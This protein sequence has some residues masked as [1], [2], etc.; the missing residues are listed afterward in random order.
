MKRFFIFVIICIVVA[1]LA[2]TTYYLMSEQQSIK[3]L[4]TVYELNVGDMVDL[5]VEL[6]NVKS[7]NP[8]Q[9]ESLNP[10]VAEYSDTG[11][12]TAKAGGKAVL[13]VTSEIGGFTT[14]LIQITVG[15][16]ESDLTPLYIR[17]VDQFLHIGDTEYNSFYTLTASYRITTTNLNF[18]DKTWVPLGGESGFSGHIDFDGCIITNIT[19]KTSA[20]ANLGI[21]TKL[22]PNAVIS[23][24]I[25]EN[26]EFSG[27]CSGGVGAIAAINYGDISH[28]Y[29]NNT[30]I[31]NTHSSQSAGGIVGINYGIVERSSFENG[32]VTASK[33]AG[34]IVGENIISSSNAVVER[35]KSV[36][37]VVGTTAVGGIVGLNSGSHVIFCQ[38][39]SNSDFGSVRSSNA[40]SFIG[41]IVGENTYNGGNPSLVLDSYS[42][43]SVEGN[44]Y[45]GS[46][47]GTN[48]NI[49]EANND[50]N[51]VYG[52]YFCKDYTG[53]AAAVGTGNLAAGS[54]AKNVSSDDLATESKFF[55]Y[56]GTN[57]SQVYWDFDRVWDMKD[58]LPEVDFDGA[59]VS[60]A[61]DGIYI[62]GQ[63]VDVAGLIN[64][65]NSEA[66]LSK[67]YIIKANL[68][69]S[70]ITSWSPIGTKTSPFNGKLT[71]GVDGSGNRYKI[72]NLKISNDANS[73]LFGYVGAKGEI[74]N[75]VI[76]NTTISRGTTVGVVAAYNMGT[77]SNC[78]VK[79]S[80]SK[81]IGCTSA[82][83]DINIGGIAGF[84]GGTISGCKV[85]G[86]TI[87][88]GS[89][90]G[91][92]NYKLLYAGGITG[93]NDGTVENCINEATLD[94]KEGS[95]GNVGGLVGTNAG[96]VNLSYNSGV[97]RVSVNASSVVTGGIVGTNNGNAKLT[98]SFSD[99]TI[100]GCLA[101]GIV[102][103][104]NGTV[105]QCY[106]A[107]S[108]EGRNVGGLAY[109]VESG[110]IDNCYSSVQLSGVDSDSVKAGFAYI[111]AF[112]SKDNYGEISKC[113][114]S[115]S[116][117][118]SG[119]NW[120]ETPSLVRDPEIKIMG[121]VNPRQ[122]GYITNSMYDKDQS[123]NANTTV[124]KSLDWAILG[125]S[126]GGDPIPLSTDQCKTADK[127]LE[128]EF[129]VEYWEFKAGEYP[130]LRNV[131]KK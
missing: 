3:I 57:S 11:K 131:V 105:S 37:D 66:A 82:N 20:H 24:L 33:Y 47:L 67:S 16:G 26:C 104:A 17:N 113:F 73:G 122:A 126:D 115:C 93:Y 64:I 22:N 27:A 53:L 74:K 80:D 13:K 83:V 49:N 89:G 61:L 62:E 59:Y 116:F 63:I 51:Y 23:N 6:E 72:T 44:G 97:V 100:S 38:A 19:A 1:S 52:C 112:A 46:V 96:T 85:T 106:S 117:A 101:G 90:A 8:F 48:K 95:S 68:D 103:I 129:A 5:E 54:V 29:V 45:K 128:Q 21:F 92:Q 91:S 79:G 34:G 39:G 30:K 15:D 110:C 9:V 111:V 60:I 77:I 41:G 4:Q 58:G 56:T 7:S 86:Q 88:A 25:V 10:E 87:S 12:I 121:V 119:E 118:G 99:G 14:T 69:L 108:V 81:F 109:K 98:R 75:L 40:A 50:Y 42:I 55:S 65:A 123:T 43:N 94:V 84:N 125:G 120:Y 2:F 36:A 124:Q 28:C 76:E 107:G 114:S 102:G 78:I 70:G 35:C 31:T 18:M 130:Q 71:A 127:F 32:T